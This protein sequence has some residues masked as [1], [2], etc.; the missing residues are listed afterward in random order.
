MNEHPL[1][2]DLTKL[3]H[4]DLEKKL[5]QLNSRWYAAKRM[6][7]DQQVLGQLD[8]LLQ[9]LEYEKQRRNQQ[10]DQV[11]GVVIDTDATDA[12]AS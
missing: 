9:G 4:E 7:M 10:L 2:D 8:M 12:K 5:T 3:S 6:G 1:T 11:S